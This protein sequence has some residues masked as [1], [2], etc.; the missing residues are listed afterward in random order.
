MHHHIQTA[1]LEHDALIAFFALTALRL[2][3]LIALR[4]VLGA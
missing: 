2:A 3:Y 1:R 4:L